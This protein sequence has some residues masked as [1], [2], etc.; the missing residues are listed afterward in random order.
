MFTN[1]EHFI[2][3]LQGYI[4]GGELTEYTYMVGVRDKSPNQNEAIWSI[5]ASATTLDGTPPS[6]ERPAG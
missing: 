6:P 3:K 1:K 4:Y 5:E 2:L